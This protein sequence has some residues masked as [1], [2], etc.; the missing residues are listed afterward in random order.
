MEYHI[1]FEEFA[2]LYSSENTTPLAIDPKDG[3]IF[4][5]TGFSLGYYDP[6]K[7]TLETIYTERRLEYGVNFMFC[8]VICEESL[9][10]H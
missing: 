7:A 8:P 2:P 1:E 3:H 10:A 4:L 5:N 6:K 9:V